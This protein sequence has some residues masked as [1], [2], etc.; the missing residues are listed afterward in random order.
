MNT[1]EI[2]SIAASLYDGGW[3]ASDRRQMI[4]EYGFSDEEIVEICEVLET[5]EQEAY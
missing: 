5:Y 4:A 3:R 1:A 2:Q